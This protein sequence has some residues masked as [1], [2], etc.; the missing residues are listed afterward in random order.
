[1]FAALVLLSGVVS[2]IAL[3]PGMMLPAVRPSAA[4]GTAAGL[5]MVGCTAAMAI[6]AVGTVALVVVCRYKLAADSTLGFSGGM[7]GGTLL[8]T[9]SLVIGLLYVAT[10]IV[11]VQRLAK[12]GRLLDQRRPPRV[13]GQA[14]H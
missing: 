1:M 8:Q 6:R 12:G 9:A 2:V 7:E 11:E 3:L 10:T 14:S 5:F 13:V 4:T